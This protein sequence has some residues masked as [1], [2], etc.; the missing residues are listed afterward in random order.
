MCLLLQGTF[1]FNFSTWKFVTMFCWLFISFKRFRLKALFCA[2]Q[3]LFEFAEK[4][5][6]QN[7]GSVISWK[8]CLSECLSCLSAGHLQQVD[9]CSFL[10]NGQL[11]RF[12]FSAMFGFGGR[13]LARAEKKRWMPSSRRREY[14]VVKTL[15]RLR[16]HIFFSFS[17]SN[18]LL[19]RRKGW[20]YQW[21]YYLSIFMVLVYIIN[22]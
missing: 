3:M 22:E 19:H 1:L 7:D 2:Y 20:Q 15:A 5:R 13:S 21:R 17:H 6:Q 18:V 9:M 12:G 10:S 16:W 4:K 8:A 14:A 11:M